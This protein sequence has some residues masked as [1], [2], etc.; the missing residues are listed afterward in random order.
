[1]NDSRTIH[2]LIQCYFK[3]GDFDHLITYAEK[4]YLE[5]SLFRYGLLLARKSKF[6]EVEHLLKKI[7]TAFYR[8]KEGSLSIF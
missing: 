6:H 3:V 1:M 8:D 2:K 4:I 7:D 5:K